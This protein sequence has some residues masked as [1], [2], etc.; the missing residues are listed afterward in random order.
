MKSHY[1]ILIIGGGTAGIMLAAQ[2]RNKD[3]KLN[4]AIL[5]PSAHHWYQ[6]AWTLVGAGTY[7]YAHTRREEAAL[8][9]KGVTWLQDAATGFSPDQQLVYTRQSG[10][11]SYDYLVVAPGLAYNLDGIEG[12]ATALSQPNVSSNYI[13]P[14]KTW[15]VI[16]N[17]K[18]GNAVFTQPATPIKCGGAPQKIMYL[19]DDYFRQQ[20]I[21]PKSNVVFATPAAA[22]FGV[23]AF[24]KTL[25]QVI[26]RKKVILK[27][28]YNPVKID[29]E[30]NE[31]HFQLLQASQ[32][33]P[34]GNLR[35][36]LA[37]QQVVVM[38][39]DMLHLAP[40]QQAPEFIRTSVLAVPDGPNQGWL[41]VDMHTLQHKRYANVYGLGD[42]AAL[43]TSKT[44][45][46]IRKQV[47]VVV[48]HLLAQVNQSTK[49][50]LQYEGYTSC[51]LVTGYGKMV[52]AEFKYNNVVDSDPLLSKL[53]DTTQE[54]W[55]MW[56][57]KKYGLPWLYWNRMMK[58]KM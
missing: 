29:S 57:L 42:V 30:N 56:L 19:A 44:G 50:Q 3:K 12:L 52:L 54:Q 36:R 14:V 46:A 43:P 9:P 37:D 11:L 28:F 55:S 8:I 35:E 18:G 24:A 7:N 16:Q 15:Q 1:Q 20:G 4:I 22:I 32:A 47:P 49:P 10:L 48:A 34:D 26:D 58:G 13:D 2:L 23:P 51:P 45:A 6:P 21:R 27:T 38:P 25:M 40:P 39:Y 41:E 53:M 5:E 33:I 17:F 31:I